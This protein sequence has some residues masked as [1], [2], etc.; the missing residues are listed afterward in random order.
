MVQCR[1]VQCFNFR[2]RTFGWLMNILKKIDLAFTSRIKPEKVVLHESPITDEYK[3]AS[4]FQE[5]SSDDIDCDFLE[6]H[7][8]AI[9]GMSPE[10]FLYFLP[11]IYKA[12]FREQRPEIRVCASLINMLDRSNIPSS[13]D[14]FFI[15]RWAALT[16]EECDASQE[17]ILWLTNFEDLF[18][19]GNELTRAYDTL[20]VISAQQS[21]TP[22]AKLSREQIKK[23]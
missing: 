22:I 10:A 8:D 11:G 19:Y 14:T 3:D 13:W 9:F 21:A 4:F 16:P 15:N 23:I 2:K 6:K 20:S 18:V 17:W 7:C 1:Q 5:K 12:I